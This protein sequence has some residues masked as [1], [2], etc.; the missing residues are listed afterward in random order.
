MS[1]LIS[2]SANDVFLIPINLVFWGFV[3]IYV[4]HILE[5]SIL[6]EVFVEKIKHRYFPDYNWKMFFWF[7]SFLLIL[8][9][10]AVIVFEVKGGAW[11]ILP[12]S[13]AVERVYNGFYHLVETIISRKYSSGLL[14]SVPSWILG[15]I[16][17]RYS[18]LKGEI[19]TSHFLISAVIGFFIFS[20]MIFPLITGLLYKVYLL[21]DIFKKR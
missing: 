20:L 14:T 12:L 7:N 11:I 18:L 19:Q 21:K 5:E 16:T 6:P 15:Y 10:S 8:N 9:I 13:L 3:I 17:V 2:A 1:I 4:L